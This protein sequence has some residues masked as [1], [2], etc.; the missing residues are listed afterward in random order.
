M[1]DT[2]TLAPSDAE[3][4]DAAPKHGRGLTRRICGT[5]ASRDPIV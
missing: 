5:E 1:T 3:I 4:L 2:N